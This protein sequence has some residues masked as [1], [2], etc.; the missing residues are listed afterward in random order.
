MGPVLLVENHLGD[1]HLVERLLKQA[2]PE[3]PVKVTHVGN[4][5]DAVA[6][7]ADRYFTVVVVDSALVVTLGAEIISRLAETGNGAAIVVIGETD[8]DAFASLAFRAGAQ[9][10]L[11]KGQLTQH[12]LLR[13]IRYA[14][15]RRRAQAQ[16]TQLAQFDQ[17]T[18]V[19]NRPS[20]RRKLSESVASASRELHPFALLHLDL[21]RFKPIN[22][23]LGDE[24]GDKLLRA[25]AAR[26]RRSV[27]STGFVARLG[28]DEFAVGATALTDPEEAAHLAESIGASLSAPFRI[29]GEELYVTA[30]IGI[31]VYPFDGDQ[32]RQIARRAESAMYSARE[33]GG[34]THAFYSA[35]M[36]VSESDRFRLAGGLRR[37]LKREEFVLHYQPKVDPTSGFA[38]GLEALIRWRHPTEGLISPL[39]F[40]PLLEE[41][42]QIVE[43]GA[44]ALRAVCDQMNAWDAEGVC[45]LPVAVN[46]SARQL[47]EGGFAEQVAKIIAESNVKPQRLEL[48]ITESLLIDDPDAS[49]ATLVRLNAIGVKLSIDDFGVGYSSLNY[50]ANFPV[51]TLKIDQSFVHDLPADPNKAVLVAGIIALAQSLGLKVV[52]EGIETQVQL[53][54][55]RDFGVDAVQG[56]LHSR[57]LPVG[58]LTRWLSDPESWT[59]QTV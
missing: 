44:W 12:G 37:A 46:V 49:R 35:E 50:L 42:G 59:E 47:S 43:V 39:R 22:A 3:D 34:N 51:H 57:P 32:A 23:T 31:A 9:D 15:E 58:A 7:L 27:G 30:S 52:A 40:I 21:D 17:L 16:L 20:F 14:V 55:L 45:D 2:R 54:M 24:M 13:A 41:T 10:F 11:V 53:K 6:C 56:Y 19:Y 48:E 26:I 36:N 8:D 29:G 25:A 28:P 4:V 5:D 33:R 18:G 38:I 1:A